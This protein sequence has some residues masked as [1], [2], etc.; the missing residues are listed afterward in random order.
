MNDQAVSPR[1]SGKPKA[2]Q[3]RNTEHY[4][5]RTLFPVDTGE[6]IDWAVNNLGLATGLLVTTDGNITFAPAMVPRMRVTKFRVCF[7]VQGCY[8]S[9]LY[10]LR[11]RYFGAR[12][13]PAEQFTVQISNE[14]TSSTQFSFEIPV[15]DV[16][17]NGSFTCALNVELHSEMEPESR[18]AAVAAGIENPKEPVLLR[19]SWLEIRTWCRRQ[20][21]CGV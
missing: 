2:S 16:D 3:F 15:G 18:A 12:G 7:D 9:S 6:G 11:L 19:G 21:L 8:L 20:H 17:P 10:K 1:R 13:A 4:P 14:S 5:V